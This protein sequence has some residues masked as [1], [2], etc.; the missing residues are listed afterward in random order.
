MKVTFAV[1]F[2]RKNNQIGYYE[3]RM[4]IF[5]PKLTYNGPTG[6]SPSLNTQV[7][8]ADSISSNPEPNNE[9][10][11]PK[12][13]AK[14]AKKDE[15]EGQEENKNLNDAL[16]SPPIINKRQIQNLE[17]ERDE[18]E[19]RVEK[20]ETENQNLIAEVEEAKMEVMKFKAMVQKSP[21][22]QLK[23]LTKENERLNNLLVRKRGQSRQEK[24][25]D[26][27][28]Y[29]DTIDNLEAK[30][31]ELENELAE[32]KKSEFEA[33]Q[34]EIKA[35]GKLRQIEDQLEEAEKRAQGKYKHFEELNRYI[36]D[37][38]IEKNKM[39][40]Q[41][42][43]RARQT[44]NLEYKLEEAEKEKVSDLE[45][46]KLE[47]EG[48]HQSLLEMERLKLNEKIKRL[49]KEGKDLSDAL[50]DARK[51]IEG[52]QKSEPIMERNLVE[53]GLTVIEDSEKLYKKV[54]GDFQ[55]FETESIRDSL[56]KK[57][58]ETLMMILDQHFEEIKRNID[59]ASKLI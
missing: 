58:R 6:L 34:N 36:K 3:K 56:L 15:N 33:R 27:E 47:L 39:S 32:K 4:N 25:E 22:E 41:L 30:V 51:E 55:S 50:K 42:T 40:E 38:L 24:A 20:L 48:E 53:K 31:E 28:F 46:Q 19:N 37:L 44:A 35:T 21:E 49:E 26:K 16:M 2:K 8:T 23:M 13:L 1:E 12:Q 18:L 7:P 5:R 10:E 43:E 14:S 54:G 17:T 57:D 29:Q 9:I 52:F 11:Q 59:R 45:M